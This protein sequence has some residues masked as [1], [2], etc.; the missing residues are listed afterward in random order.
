MKTMEISISKFQDFMRLQKLEAD[1][2]ASLS[3]YLDQQ[4]LNLKRLERINSIAQLLRDQ[5]RGNE[6]WFKQ[7]NPL[8]KEMV[9]RRYYLTG[10]SE[11]LFKIQELM[12]EEKENG[13]F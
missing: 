6:A 12:Q 4:K 10:F 5:K 11:K 3:F 8:I 13:K 7:A 9:K 2:T 1:L